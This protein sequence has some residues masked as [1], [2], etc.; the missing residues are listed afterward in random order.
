MRLPGLAAADLVDALVGPEKDD[1]ESSPSGNP[2]LMEEVGAMLMEGRDG[3]DEAA[4]SSVTTVTALDDG[5]SAPGSPR[6]KCGDPWSSGF[7]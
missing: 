3:W 4:A 6:S 2:R 7:F 5:A 1:P